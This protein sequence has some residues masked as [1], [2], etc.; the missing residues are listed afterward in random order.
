MRQTASYILVSGDGLPL[1]LRAKLVYDPAYV[2]VPVLE[3]EG[4][5][6]PL[7]QEAILQGL[8][9][10]LPR[11]A[12]SSKLPRKAGARQQHEHVKKKASDE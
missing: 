11:S 6:T 9:C 10:H 1:A 7:E 8:R 2:I 5:A 12:L 3:N 4:G